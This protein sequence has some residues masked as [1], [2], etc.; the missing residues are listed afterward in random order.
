M[1]A[2]ASRLSSEAGFTLLRCPAC[3]TAEPVPTADLA[4]A[5]RLIACGKCGASFPMRELRRARRGSARALKSGDG[6]LR[7]APASRPP[8]ER[9]GGDIRAQ[10]VV[11][12]AARMPKRRLQLIG[13]ALASALLAAAFVLG[14]EAATAAAPDLSGL[15]AAIGLAA[16]RAGLH[17]EDL[18]AERDGTSLALRGRLVNAT[19]R[20]MVA[21]DLAGG[22]EP[23]AVARQRDELH[24]EPNALKGQ[25]ADEVGAEDEGAL[26]DDD[27]E[28][29]FGA[30]G[31][32]LGR[33]PRDAAGQVLRREKRPDGGRRG[34]HGRAPVAAGSGCAQPPLGRTRTV[35]TSAGT[36]S[37]R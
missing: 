29:V 5:V 20:K 11:R 35:A 17:V 4:D 3:A 8:D 34:R 19:R 1:P 30:R 16:E 31:G 15:H 22:L 36:S 25:R 37:S 6:A 13:A 10:A 9:A 28:E 2:P 24:F 21:T 7:A 33:Q 32:D 23:R 26:Q 27:D 18:A 12:A 14:R